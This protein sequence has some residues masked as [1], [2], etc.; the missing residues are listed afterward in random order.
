VWE[1]GADVPELPTLVAGIDGLTRER[2][3]D[4]DVYR[5]AA[6]NSR[7]SEAWIAL[8]T[9]RVLVCATRRAL[10]EEALRQVGPEVGHLL[11]SLGCN[12]LIDWDAPIVIVRQ[13]D[14]TS[15]H[16]IYSPL[17]T[18]VPSVGPQTRGF[19]V[20]GFLLE[21]R[22]G[23][24]AGFRIWVRTQEPDRARRYYQE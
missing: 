17:N 16:D 8:P 21:F 15:S 9:N 12:R 20:Q 3:G 7:P 23:N 10:L 2:V 6:S 13:Y 14:L 1:A 5:A 4:R 11:V 22:P 24:A 19:S 18:R